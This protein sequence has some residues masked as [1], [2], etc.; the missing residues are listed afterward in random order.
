M[1]N[2]KKSAIL[3]RI[4]VIAF[5]FSLI[6]SIVVAPQFFDW[7]IDTRTIELSGT[8]GYFLASFYCACVPAAVLLISLYR[9]LSNIQKDQ[10]F[11]KVNT[12][13][14]RISSWCCIVAAII[15]CISMIYYIPFIFVA[16]AAAF[17]A[18]IIRVIKNVF[19]R[20]IALQE[21]ADYT[22]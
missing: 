22:I 7:F 12:T 14:L 9:L 21:E 19:S 18:L 4:I 17:M 8:K 16:I 11:I 2:E 20:A 6:L 3:S 13:Y 1:W 15:C 10:V 5:G